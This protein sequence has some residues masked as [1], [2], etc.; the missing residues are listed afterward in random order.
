LQYHDVCAPR[1]LLF[2]TAHGVMRTARTFAT[3]LCY[4]SFESIYNILQAPTADSN[5]RRQLAQHVRSRKQQL[6]AL[7]A[8]PSSGGRGEAELVAMQPSDVDTPAADPSFGY[9]SIPAPRH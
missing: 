9:T 5:L 8:G 6:I 2:V 7:I 3:G 1:T 4:I